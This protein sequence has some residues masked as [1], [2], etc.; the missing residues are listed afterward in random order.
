M[1]FPKIRT[2]DHRPTKTLVTENP[3][4][5][6]IKMVTLTEIM[7]LGRICLT[8]MKTQRGSISK[9]SM[10]SACSTYIR[11]EDWRT[12]KN[13]LTRYRYQHKYDYA[14][15]CTLCL[16]KTSPF[17]LFLWYLCQVSSD[18]ANFLQHIPGN[19]K[20]TQMCRQPHLVSYVR[21]VLCKI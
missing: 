10:Q 9:H 18:S 8:Y 14:Q 12:Y 2:M 20:Q 21:T 7:P 16:K 4:L 6:M 15:I 5:S 17:F 19:L 3:S 1:I 11:W 13:A